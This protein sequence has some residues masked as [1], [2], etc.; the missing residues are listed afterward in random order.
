MSPTTDPDLEHLVVDMSVTQMPI[1]HNDGGVN[2]NV[3]EDQ[4]MLSGG[5]TVTGEPFT[6]FSGE[7]N[8]RFRDIPREVDMDDGWKTESDTPGSNGKRFK[9]FVIPTSNT[10]FS[11]YC[12]QFIGQGASYC[13]AR[14]CVTAHHHA[15]VKA[16]KPG[17][18]YVAKSPTTAFVTPSIHEACID[19]RRCVD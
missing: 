8:R 14:N 7:G 6:V 17:E 12:F 15:L 1:R 4:G 19:R 10:A 18:I 9:T 5:S 3:N 13:T 11:A 2:G 16:V